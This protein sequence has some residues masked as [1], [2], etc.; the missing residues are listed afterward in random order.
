MLPPIVQAREVIEQA[1]IGNNSRVVVYDDSNG[2]WASRLFWTL[3]YL[4]HRKVA[5]LD[6]GLSSWVAAGRDL[7]SEEVTK[8]RASF[9]VR[10]QA[11]K[12]DRNQGTFLS[13]DELERLYEQGEA[14]RDR[15]IVTHCQ[16]GIRAAHTYFTL[17][18]L[19]YEEVRL[20]DGSWA[21][22]GNSE[23]IPVE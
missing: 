19:G 21:E 7:H 11:D 15:K 1:G 12:L 5:L 9:Q 16:T 6:G 13:T 2:L 18:L 3:E 22:W 20:Y 10:I 17:R 14:T 23:E 8:P 4:G